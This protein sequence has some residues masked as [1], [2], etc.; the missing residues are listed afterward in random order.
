MPQP[1]SSLP[2]RSLLLGGLG[3]GAVLVAGCGSRS[4]DTPS[5]AVEPTGQAVGADSGLVEQVS[6]EVAAALVAATATARRYRALRP[7]AQPFADLH[8]AHLESLDATADDSEGTA[9]AGRP[10]ALAALLRTEAK[11]Q[12]SLVA[13]ALEAESGAL[14]QVFASMAAAVAQRRA[15]AA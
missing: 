14:A 4:A 3:A 15:V 5:E 9:P 10:A 1:R 12:R 6:G 2:R 11:L 8:L 13:A 7:V